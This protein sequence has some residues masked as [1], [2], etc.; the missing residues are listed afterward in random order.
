MV[1]L[2]AKWYL[3]AKRTKTTHAH[4]PE[5]LQA[6]PFYSQVFT[7]IV[8][9]SYKMETQKNVDGCGLYNDPSIL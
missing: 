5:L 2:I 9:A 7:H 1:L 3:V 8:Q 4:P 6:Q